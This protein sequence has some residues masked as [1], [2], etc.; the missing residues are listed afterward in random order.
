MRKKNPQFA[1]RD[2]FERILE[3]GVIPTF[4]LIVW[5]S[6]RGV[7]LLRRKIAPYKNT[8]ALPGLRMMKPEGI[9]DT[10]DRIARNE[11]GITIDATNRQFI[12]QYVGRFRTEQ[13]RQDLSTCYALFSDAPDIAINKEHFSSHCFVKT[14]EDIPAKTGGMYNFFLSLFFSRNTFQLSEGERK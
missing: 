7:I 1:P 3:Y 6:D 12:G 2:I 14:K 9:E 8:W 13:N 4:D 5:F 11:I 10:L